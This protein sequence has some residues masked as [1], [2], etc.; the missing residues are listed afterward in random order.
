MTLFKTTLITLFIGP[1]LCF[2]APEQSL[3]AINTIYDKSLEKIENQNLT[4]TM[5]VTRSYR[6]TL[7]YLANKYQQQGA[8]DPVMATQQEIKHFDAGENIFD[9]PNANLPKAALKA[10]SE[11][12]ANIL[13]VEL[14]KAKSIIQLT[15]GYE[16]VIEKYVK[17]QT[18]EGNINNALSAREQVN[19]VKNTPVYIKAQ[20]LTSG[21]VPLLPVLVVRS[22]RTIIFFS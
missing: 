10:R 1:I 14:E 15:Q 11:C 21:L 9:A 5:S 7:D 18:S 17:T 12:Q 2:S 13:K 20:D 4:Q 16:V 3:K 19:K 22:R 8:L 6:K